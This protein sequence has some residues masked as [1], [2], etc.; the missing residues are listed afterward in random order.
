[1]ASLDVE[2]G[3]RDALELRICARAMSPLLPFRGL[4]ITV[5]DVLSYL[6]AGMTVMLRGGSPAACLSACNLEQRP[7]RGVHRS[8]IGKRRSDVGLEH[9]HIGPRRVSVRVLASD[10]GP[11]ELGIVLRQEFIGIS[12]AAGRPAVLDGRRVPPA[13]GFRAFLGSPTG[14]L[15]HRQCARHGLL[16]AR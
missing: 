16:P 8:R 12:H 15:L 4:R 14:S 5:D 6:A 7:E 10:P 9:D 11:N 13:L 3:R 1:M 2:H